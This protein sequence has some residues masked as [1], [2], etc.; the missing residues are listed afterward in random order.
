MKEMTIDEIKKTLLG[1]LIYV[2]KVCKENSI[3]YSLADGT[4]LGAVRHKGFIPWDD[5]VDVMLERNEYNKLLEAL[6]KDSDNNYKVFSLNDEGYFYPYAKVSD[7]KTLIIEKNWPNDLEL[8]VNIDIFPID[9]VPEGQEEEYYDKTQSYVNGLFDCL[10]NIAYAHDK[11][12]MR[13]I[14]RLLRFR[15]VRKNRKKGECYW[16]SKINQITC[17]KETGTLMR[18]VEGK[19]LSLQKNIFEK[20]IELEFENYKFSAVKEY[21]MVLKSMYGDYMK[22]PPECER[23]TNHDFVAYLK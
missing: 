13:L 3:K 11:S 4:L 10:T 7:R 12:Y 18:L 5:D 20:F 21:D 16:K 17:L 15:K 14:K 22:L 19:Y 23:V 6:Y 1:I 8:G 9:Y 2:D